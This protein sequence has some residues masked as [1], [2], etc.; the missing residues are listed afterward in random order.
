MDQ[1]ATVTLR[2][3]KSYSARGYTF[4][5]GKPLTISKEEDIAYFEANSEFLVKRKSLPKEKVVLTAPKPEAQP[6]EEAD[7]DVKEN[8]KKRRKD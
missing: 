3:A 2:G 5:N 7:Q 8:N 1:V 6:D 4:Q